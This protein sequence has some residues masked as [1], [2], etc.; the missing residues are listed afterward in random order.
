DHG[1]ADAGALAA[2]RLDRRRVAGVELEDREV[3][4]AV[5]AHEAGALAPAVGED[6]AG[7][8][9]AEVV[10]GGQDA[11]LG[12]HDAG[13]AAPARADPDDGGP[14]FGGDPGNQ[15][16]G[17]QQSGHLLLPCSLQ[18]ASD[19]IEGGYDCFVDAPAI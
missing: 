14:G 15:V 16:R 9:A 4:V 8:V 6:D 12:D 13:A 11:A 18:F 5:A 7:A 1:G 19:Y 10:G 3:E 2:R 17:L